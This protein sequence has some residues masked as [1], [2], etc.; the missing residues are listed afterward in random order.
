MT[1]MM[2]IIMMLLL[3]LLMKNDKHKM[4]CLLLLGSLDPPLCCTNSRSQL[5]K[6]Y[7]GLF[8]INT[9]MQWF[10]SHCIR[11]VNNLPQEWRFLVPPIQK[12]T[13]C[14]MKVLNLLPILL[15]VLFL[16][17]SFL[18]DLPKLSFKKKNYKYHTFE[19]IVNILWQLCLKY[20]DLIKPL[21]LLF[22]AKTATYEFLVFSFILLLA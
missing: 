4:Q 5:E 7:Q 13:L 19:D 18:L 9:S 3:T 21:Q 2:T 14:T 10:H 17:I 11:H 16:L 15:E 8:I 12:V 6:S 20:L 1:M 22:L